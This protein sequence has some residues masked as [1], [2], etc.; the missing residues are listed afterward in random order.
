[1]PKFIRL[2]AGSLVCGFLRP[3]NADGDLRPAGLVVC[4]PGRFDTRG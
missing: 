1:V 3:R 4:V 2:T